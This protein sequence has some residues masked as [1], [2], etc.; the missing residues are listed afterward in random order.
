MNILYILKVLN[1]DILLYRDS[2]KKI[3]LYTTNSQVTPMKQAAGLEH[4]L[5]PTHVPLFKNKCFLQN[6]CFAKR[7]C[8]PPCS[9]DDGCNY[10]FVETF[11]VKVVSACLDL[12]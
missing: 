1:I 3:S 7:T 11:S 4:R 10:P 9:R 8:E 12:T 5:P 6:A 2:N